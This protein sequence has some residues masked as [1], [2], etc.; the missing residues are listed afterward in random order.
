MLVGLH[1]SVLDSLPSGLIVI[2]TEGS[3]LIFNRA[4]RRIL[5]FEGRLLEENFCRKVFSGQPEIADVLMA[6]TLTLHE[7]NRQ[8]M[9]VINGLGHRMILGYGTLVFHSNEGAPVGVGMVCQD[10]TRFVPIPVNVR[11]IALTNFFFMPFMAAMVF[12]ALVWGLSEN[13]EKG[14]S[15]S[16]MAGLIAF[17]IV[18]ARRTKMAGERAPRI[19]SFH[20]P[21]N[22]LVSGLLFYLLGTLWGPMWLLFALTPLATGIYAS[23][24]TTFVVAVISAVFLLGIYEQR[25]LS[26]GVGWAQAFVHALFI[27]MIS[28]FVNALAALVGKVRNR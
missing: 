10:I 18:V 6:T 12:S 14:L 2:D 26:G 21:V 13:W 9:R 5:G 16:V 1:E 11:F 24:R 20:A 25:G 23:W 4:A 17:N 3:I 22:F 27:V 28:M 7:A 8:E 19:A 15:V